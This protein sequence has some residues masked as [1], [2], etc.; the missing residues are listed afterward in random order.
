MPHERQADPAPGVSEQTR[1]LK[2]A[3]QIVGIAERIDEERR[4]QLWTDALTCVRDVALACLPRSPTKAKEIKKTITY[5]PGCEVTVTYSVAGDAQMPYGSDRYVLFGIQHL[6]RLQDSPLVKFEKAGELLDLFGFEDGGQNYRQLRQRFDR[7]KSLNIEIETQGSAVLNARTKVGL[8]TR[9]IEAWALP[10]R[11]E[12]EAERNG[13][14]SLLPADDEQHYVRLSESLFRRLQKGSEDEN[15]LLLRLDL[16]RLFTRNPRG[17]DFCVFLCHR[18]GSAKRTSVVPHSFLM[19]FF[20]NGPSEADKDTIRALKKIHKQI[21]EAT[22]GALRS[23]F[24]VVGLD[25][26]GGRRPKKVWGLKVHPSKSVVLDGAKQF[27][28]E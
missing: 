6:A 15:I 20:K 21:M 23:E 16:L 1:A 10:T 25:R 24:V 4:E 17:W 2:K 13:Q 3:R 14:T 9:L 22:N 27:L 28:P 8:G 26:S 5:A 18:C 12:I 19:E 7:L 11:S